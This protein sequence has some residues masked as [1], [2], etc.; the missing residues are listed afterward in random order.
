MQ[1]D[2]IGTHYAGAKGSTINHLGVHGENRK[3]KKKYF[4]YNTF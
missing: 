1:A 2:F 3:K 4:T